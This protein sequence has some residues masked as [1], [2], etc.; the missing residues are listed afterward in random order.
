MKDLDIYKITIDEEYSENGEDLGIDQIAFTKNPAIKIKGM[1]FNSQVKHILFK[2]EVK[3][4]IAAPVL[5]PMDNIYRNDESGEYYVQFTKEVIEK[6]HFKFMKNLNNSGNFNLEHDS[7]KEVPAFILESWLVGKKNKEDRSYS[8]FGINVP[9]G[10]MFIVAQ[11]TDKEYYN[12]LV[13][14]NQV[15]FSIEGFLGMKLSEIIKE[16]KIEDMPKELM[17]PDGEHI[18]GD[19]N[20][21]VSEGK[22]V[23]I[24]EIKSELDPTSCGCGGTK[25]AEIAPEPIPETETETEVETITID[26]A[27]ILEIVQPKLDE[28]YKVIADMK[29][30][31]D[32]KV[33]VV[34]EKK[35]EEVTMSVAQKFSEIKK[36]INK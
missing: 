13:K 10:T 21:V 14:E 35:I 17:L 9:E 12:N 15:G 11:I 1:A 20:Y 2:D 32:K 30:L 22:I 28:L 4:R 36:F 18:I 25:L 3:M 34:E 23:E 5:I 7:N 26:E 33:D 31:L 29:V 27:K 16:K 24:K 8:E 19:K 6:I